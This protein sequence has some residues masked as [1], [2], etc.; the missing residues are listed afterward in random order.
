LGK[1]VSTEESRGTHL[2]IP[3]EMCETPRTAAGLLIFW[4][5]CTPGTKYRRL[6]GLW[7]ARSWRQ[8]QEVRT[9]FS[10]TTLQYPLLTML[11][12]QLV[13]KKNISGL[14]SIFTV[15]AKR[16]TTVLLTGSTVVPFCTGDTFQ[17]VIET[18][19]NTKPCIYYVFSYI[20]TCTYQW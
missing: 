8:T 17:Y 18:K 20:F 2:Q 15:E 4:S 10:L 5:P 7:E 12:G 6:V 3:P 16:L 13:K 19:D 1:N 11:H 9:V 14:E